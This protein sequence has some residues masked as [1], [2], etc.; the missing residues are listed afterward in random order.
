[1]TVGGSRPGGHIGARLSGS[2]GTGQ[3][4]EGDENHATARRRGGVHS[5][6]RATASASVT[7]PIS[8]NDR[9]H[10]YPAAPQFHWVFGFSCR[11]HLGPGWRRRLA[12]AL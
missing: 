7:S 11:R 3:A 2:G 5:T 10:R 8:S 4:R 12:L 9:N 1:M 6:T